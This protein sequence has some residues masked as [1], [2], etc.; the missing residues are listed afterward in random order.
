LSFL[1][2]VVYDNM[3]T[4]LAFCSAAC[5]ILS[6][7]IAIIIEEM[8]YR[9]W[10]H[11]I[12]FWSGTDPVSLLILFLL[13]FLL[14]Q[15]LQK[16]PMLCQLKSD[17]DEIQQDCFSS[18]I[19]IDWWSPIFDLTSHLQDRGHDVILCRKALPPGECTCSVC[20]TKCTY[21]A[22]SASSWSL[23]HLHLLLHAGLCINQVTAKADIL[24][25]HV[26]IHRK[27]LYKCGQL[28][29]SLEENIVCVH[30]VTNRMLIIDVLD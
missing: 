18:K 9:R 11:T 12:I 8:C 30:V 15:S 27:L 16:S 7:S 3:K 21:T 14:G 22:L 29:L 25:Q 26:F 28:F 19:C 20:P 6:Q 4:S 10:L 5:L 17:Q 23:V 13:F 1:F 2:T 24:E